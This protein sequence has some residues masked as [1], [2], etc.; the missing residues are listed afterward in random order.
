MIDVAVERT[1][2]VDRPL[3]LRLTLGPLGHG[4]GDPT[5]R[6]ETGRVWRATRTPLGPA[7]VALA[8]MGATIRVTA[9]GPGAEWALE[10]APAL[11]GLDDDPTLLEPHHPIV[12]ELARR[13]P[14]LRIGRTA[15]VMEALVPAIIEQKVTGTE[16]RRAYRALV[17]VHGEPAPGPAGLR[18]PPS[19][20]T[21]AALPYHAFHPLGLERRRADTL[22]RVASRARAL[23]A[24]VALPLADAYRR[25]MALPGIGPWTAA[26]V[27]R[28]ALGDPDAVSV[29]DFHLPNL[30]SWA[31]AGEPRGDDSR[32]LE[33]LEP[34]RGQ[35]G[36][37][38]RLLEASGLRAPRY[39]PPMSPRPTD[40]W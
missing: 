12:R 7:T 1:I 28:S 11:V 29:G 14:G 2:P 6:F 22:R 35:R 19:P 36:R 16:A 3:D 21:I 34:Y 27:G 37:V 15:A 10:A 13:M 17:R 39:G 40:N 26:E 30:V 4:A 31:L 24:A 9:W 18:L 38:V 32:M 33:L 23:E 25:L 20:D 8:D 5:I